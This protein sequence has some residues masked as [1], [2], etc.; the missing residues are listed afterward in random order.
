MKKMD[1][2]FENPIDYFII[3]KI[4]EPLSEYI[5][6]NFPQTTPNFITFIGLICGL[7]SIFFLINNFYFL[8][9]IFFW[10]CYILDCLDGYYARKYDMVTKFGDYFDHIRD[11]IVNFIIV[12][13]ILSKLKKNERYIFMIL[14]LMFFIP[15]NMHLGFQNNEN[16]VLSLLSHICHEDQDL[17]TLKY[18]GCGTYMLFISLSFIYLQNNTV[19]F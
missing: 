1:D 12:L 7:I 15:M 3:N 14:F 19:G 9:F 5:H 13:V 16:S 8:A 4:C 17:H 6:T 18:F 10:I 11:I 2:E